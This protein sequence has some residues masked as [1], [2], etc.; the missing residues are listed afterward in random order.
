MNSPITASCSHLDLEKQMVLRAKRLT[1]VRKVR[2]LR[3][4]VAGKQPE[5]QWLDMDSA[6]K[7]RTTGVSIWE[8][9]SNDKGSEPDVSWLMLETFPP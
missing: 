6:I 5:L 2:R 3:S 9:A 4:I 7:H 1:R 8:W